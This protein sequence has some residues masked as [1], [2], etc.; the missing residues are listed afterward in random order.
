MQFGGQTPL[1]LA[2]G[3]K[4]HGATARRHPGVESIE[5]AE[6]RDLF[7]KVVEKVG[8]RQPPNGMAD[9]IEE[10]ARDRRTHRLPGRRAPELRA[11]RPRDGGRLRQ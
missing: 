9:S 1:N 2:R 8:L 10:R 5:A 7:A 11:R 6:D 4:D 3:L